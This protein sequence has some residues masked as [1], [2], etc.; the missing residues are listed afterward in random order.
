MEKEIR[1]LTII[2][3]EIPMAIFMVILIYPLL[4]S[5]YISFFDYNLLN[6]RTPEFVG[7]QN[8]KEA[9]MQK[10]F[11]DSVQVTIIFVVLSV[12]LQMLFGFSLA[13]LL[14]KNFKGANTLRS[15]FCF[16]M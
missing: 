13:L 2:L 15:A 12:G 4:Y 8:Y 9:L 7:L 10:E 1:R 11:W 3:L 14:Y 5:L 16:L 6:G